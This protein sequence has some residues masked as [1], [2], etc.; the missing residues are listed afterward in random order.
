M[1]II[2]AAGLV[3]EFAD[4]TLFSNVNFSVEKG[5]KIGFIGANGAGKTTL[6]KIIIGAESPSGGGVVRQS[7]IKVG[8]LEQHACEGSDKTAFFETL[9]VFS[10]LMD[11]EAELD[12]ISTRLLSSN[13]A[14]L[15]ERQS[16][17]TERFNLE[18][19]L[20]FRSRT[21]AVLSGLGFSGEET[22]LPISA[23]SGGQRAKI[24][25]AKLLLCKNDLILLDEP[26]NHLDIDA[27]AWLEEFLVSYTGAVI[28]ISHDRYFL[29]K[30]TTKTMELDSEKL[31]FT[32]GNFSRYLEL[33]NQRLEAMERDYENKAKEIKRI[34]GIVEQ[35]RRWNREKNIKTAESKLKQ[36]DRI[37]KT[38]EKPKTESHRLK[39]SFPVKFLSGETVLEV[40][41]DSCVFDGVPLYRDIS[42]TVR[43]GEKVCLIGPNG[44]G[45][46]TLLKRLVSKDFPFVF[47]YGVGVDLGYFDQFQDN[48]NKALDPFSE[49][50]NTYPFMTDTEV[51]NNLA[52]FEFKGDDVFKSNSSLSGGERARVA[53]LKLMLSGNNF[54]VLDEPTNHLDLYSRKALEEALIGY[55]GTLLIVSH[56][57]YFINKLA[58]KIVLLS[59][60]GATTILGNFDDYL[61]YVE[62]NKPSLEGETKK[63][64]EPHK[65]GKE[66][67]INKKKQRSNLARLRNAVSKCENEIAALEKENED[68]KAQIDGCGSDYEKLTQLTEKLS[69]NEDKLLALMDEWENASAELTS[70]LDS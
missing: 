25:L 3:K 69:L 20:T 32:A 44:I 64:E 18:G 48:I 43:R 51:R 50:H 6:F 60:S 19:G 34:E 5:D 56:D 31:Y 42:F 58:D 7:G 47:K 61:A 17:L 54:L 46:S 16:F 13:D 57:R 28:I 35:Q 66:E 36:I 67:Y 10:D 22:E 23:L 37:A 11:M 49:I 8:Y 21:A 27:I 65:K 52:A 15:I 38:M 45:K 12:E 26:T 63:T 14:A 70:A 33:K 9:E 41:R 40:E 1:S 39:I 2:S 55:E 53:L 29:D 24:G 59:P 68:I 4:R 30:V 62:K